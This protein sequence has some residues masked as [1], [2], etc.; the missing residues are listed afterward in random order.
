MSRNRV[1]FIIV[2]GLA[3]VFVAGALVAERLGLF[4]LPTRQTEKVAIQ[5]W[6]A[7]SMADWA[8]AAARQFNS[9][10]RDASVEVKAV[11]SLSFSQ[12]YRKAREAVVNGTAEPSALPVAWIPEATFIAAVARE[13]GAPFAPDGRPVAYTSLLWGAFSDREEVLVR[14][15]GA[16]NWQAVHEAAQAVDWSV[17]G[18]DASLQPWGRFKLTIAS[19]TRSAEGL[20]ALLSAAAIYYERAELTAGD[21]NDPA[22]LAWLT[23]IVDSV[24]NF[25]TLGPNPAEAMAT[26]GSSIGDVGLLTDA[27]WKRSGI[28]GRGDFT[29]VRPEYD[30][31]FDYPYIL[32]ADLAPNSP[33]Q[34][35]AQAFG[36]Y[37]LA[38]A[39][40]DL[41]TYGFTPAAAGPA[42][43]DP[44][45]RIQPGGEAALALLRWAERERIGQ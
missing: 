34:G 22:F 30:L 8:I 38:E 1:F 32:R 5:V 33:E 9:S 31:Y 27:A 44:A 16:L 41:E 3:V 18:A 20:A 10:R 4:T 15:Y 25:N 26:R 21:V 11:D 42:G 2:V 45:R 40:T 24:P 28:L 19:P 36:D 35:M 29:T 13:Q 39:Q 7:P 6:V 14:N 12:Q 43:A 23:N 17:I 37:L